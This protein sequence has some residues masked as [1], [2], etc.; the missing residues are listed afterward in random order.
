M[1]LTDADHYRRIE[2]VGQ[3]GTLEV[4]AENP[5]WYEIYDDPDTFG[6]GLR[7]T[8]GTLTGHDARAAFEADYAAYRLRPAE[9]LNTAP[10]RYAFLREH[11]YFGREFGH[12]VEST[13]RPAVGT[14]FAELPDGTVAS[15][16]G[17]PR[18]LSEY[19]HMQGDNPYGFEGDCGLVAIEG[20]LAQYGIQVDERTV[21]DHAVARGLCAI[22]DDPATSGGTSLHGQVEVLADFGVSARAAR[23]FGLEDYAAALEAGRGVIAEVNAGVLW[24]EPSYVENGQPN[25]AITI[26]GIARNAATSEVL[27]V[28]INDSG[29]D[30]RGQF[31]PASVFEAAA[32][33]AGG[34]A[35]ITDNAAPTYG[36]R[37]S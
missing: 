23:G 37:A 7:E 28:F 2:E 1:G 26:T 11:V 33:D 10:E 6:P 17:D 12:R 9:L 32:V 20:V 22:T 4:H 24:D 3:S 36:G 19:C 18:G 14:Q 8:W 16:V 29:R 35:V 27:G 5:S 13:D 30:A 31:V 15:V 21:I 34:L 25:H